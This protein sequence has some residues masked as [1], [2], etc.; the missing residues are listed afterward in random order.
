MKK[1]DLMISFI[2]CAAVVAM[3]AAWASSYP[4]GLESVAAK[5]GFEGQA[6][7][8]GYIKSPL[9]DYSIPGMGDAFW[10]TVIVGLLGLSA[11]F[12]L[13]VF[14]IK[15]FIKKGRGTAITIKQ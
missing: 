5:L 3:A 12:I 10:Q 7:E 8:V 9:P 14:I 11:T 13:T 15:F 1:K 4:D 2:I 6:V